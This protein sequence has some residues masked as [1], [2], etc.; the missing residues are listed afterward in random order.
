MVGRERNGNRNGTNHTR[1][2]N[3]AQ[4]ETNEFAS[5]SVDK[6]VSRDCAARTRVVWIGGEPLVAELA[7]N[8]RMG[9]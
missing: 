1:S 8:G 4:K 7:L 2:N 5:K 6:A 3:R 9:R